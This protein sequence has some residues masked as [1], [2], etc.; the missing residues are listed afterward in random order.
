MEIDYLE[1]EWE[2]FYTYGPMYPEYLQATKE[3]FT[4]TLTVR[5]GIL[6]G[7][8]I[9]SYV[10]EYFT[11]PATVV[12]TLVDRTLS[13]VKKYQYFLGIDENDQTYVDQ[14]QP[15]HDIHYIGQL[16]RKLFSRDY[17]VAGTWDIS[18]SY[19]DEFGNACYYSDD[20]EWEMHHKK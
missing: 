2:G 6:Y 8:L 18:G 11:E 12:G 7:T 9:D 4:L 15:G 20:G 19:L 1:G 10:R 13:L 5:D 3:H 16:K 14:T 17:F